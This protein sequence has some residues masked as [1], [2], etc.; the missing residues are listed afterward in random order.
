MNAKAPC[1]VKTR[2]TVYTTTYAAPSVVALHPP[3]SAS[4]ITVYQNGVVAGAL[5]NQEE[6]TYGA[7]QW[8]MHA[9]PL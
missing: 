2:Y 4:K 1:V 3:R 5:D 6:I 9:V 8:V 7:A